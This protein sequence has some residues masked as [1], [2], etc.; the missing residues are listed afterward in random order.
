V[1]ALAAANIWLTYQVWLGT[2]AP[3]V[4]GLPHHHCVYELFTG[5]LALGPA[6][7]LA[8]AGT[9]ALCW[10]ALLEPFR[11]R[12]PAGVATLQRTVWALGAIAI[13][14]EALI[15]AVHL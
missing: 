13:A 12:A 7:L 4:L 6:A 9:G 10:A 3:R 14:S 11:A 8:V 2:L 1:V 15:V 5:T